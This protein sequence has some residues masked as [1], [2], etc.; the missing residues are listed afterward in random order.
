MRNLRKNYD[1]PIFAARDNRKNPHLYPKNSPSQR[2]SKIILKLN[3]WKAHFM[4]KCANEGGGG[5]VA[6][7]FKCTYVAPNLINFQPPR[8]KMS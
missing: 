2:F 5:C 3:D 7:R 4:S 8:L 1:N 6:A